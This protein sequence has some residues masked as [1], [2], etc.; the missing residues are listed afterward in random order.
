MK[1]QNTINKLS[2]TKAAVVEL[3]DKK[4]TEVNGGSLWYIV[5]ELLD[6]R[7]PIIL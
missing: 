7:I 3:N 6:T 4:L 5:T 2:F 1:K